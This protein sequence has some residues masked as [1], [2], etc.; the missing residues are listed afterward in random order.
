VEKDDEERQGDNDQNYETQKH[1]SAPRMFGLADVGAFLVPSHDSHGSIE[2]LR[3]YNFLAPVCGKIRP[4][5]WSGWPPA[6]PGEPSIRPVEAGRAEVFL[7]LGR[8]KKLE[9]PTRLER[10]PGSFVFYMTVHCSWG[11]QPHDADSEV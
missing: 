5:P 3:N 8:S 1:I 11:D 7:A 9:N 10:V 4:K 2:S 6:C